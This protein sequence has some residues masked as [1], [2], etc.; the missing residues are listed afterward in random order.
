MEKREKHA[1]EI[2]APVGSYEALM[3]AIQGGAD[4]VY[5]GIGQ[6][7]MRSRSTVNF[8]L[9]DL[10]E[11]SRLCNT[12]RIKSYLTLNTII[13]DNEMTDMKEIVDAAK[14]YGITAIIASDI[15]VIS[16]AS[17]IGMEI[18]I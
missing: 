6:L 10:A 14:K 1:I 13:Y 17:S 9:D 3:A 4:A 15:S 16:Y 11:I 5:F 7:N 12:N 18:H 8:S 2:M